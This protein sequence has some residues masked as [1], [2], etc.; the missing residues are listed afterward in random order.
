VDNT[1]GPAGRA[2]VE[3]AREALAQA[4][5]DARKRGVEPSARKSSRTGGPRRPRDGGSRGGDP[6]AF[7]AAIKD[8]LASRGWEERAAV[9]GL[10]SRW[11]QI[12]GPELAEHTTPQTFEDGQ[13][14]VMADSPAWA[15]QL[16]L[17]AG[18]L[19]RRLNLDLGH[20]TVQRVKVVGP[21][22]GG[23]GRFRWSA[24]GRRRDGS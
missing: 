1:A 12:V 13:L 7:G 8:L 19:V 20:G 5:A 18:D 17:L 6:R 9:S 16:R 15:T 24:G 2:G 3:L 21:R 11:P 23:G 10:F 14:T 22:T 4:K